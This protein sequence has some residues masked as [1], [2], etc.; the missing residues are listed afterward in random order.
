MIKIFVYLFITVVFLQAFGF[1]AVWNWFLY[2]RQADGGNIIKWHCMF[3]PNKGFAFVNY[4]I[5]ACFTA[6]VVELL[7]VGD[8]I[9]YVVRMARAKSPAEEAHAKAHLTMEFKYGHQY[10]WIMLML[11]TA[12]MFSISCPLI[13]LAGLLHISVKHFTDR[14]CN[15][16]FLFLQK[17]PTRYILQERAFFFTR[18]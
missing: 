5:T 7:R 14:Y 9:C 16:R 18:I 8:L 15:S 3:L 1:G 2:V 10:A 17:L 12:I 4:L 13:A 6:N 11:S